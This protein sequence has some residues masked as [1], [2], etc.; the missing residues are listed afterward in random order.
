MM[1][2]PIA[3]T[4]VFL[5][6]RPLKVNLTNATHVLVRLKL[7]QRIVLD[8]IQVSDNCV[9]LSSIKQLTPSIVTQLLTFVSF[10]R[11]FYLLHLLPG[12]WKNTSGDC[13]NCP[14]GFFSAKQNVR[15]CTTC[16]IGWFASTL[17]NQRDRCMS[18]PR[19][20]FGVAIAATSLMEGCSNCSS[21]RFSEMEAVES[22][23][24]CKG[25]AAGKWSAVMGANSEI[26]CQNCIA[27]RY[28]RAE[29]N[30]A[31]SETSCINCPIGKYLERVGGVD[32]SLC[33]SCPI[34]YSQPSAGN[35][36]CLP[37]TPGAFQTVVGQSECL[38]CSIA[39]ASTSV[40]RS[41]DCDVCAA[42]RNQPNTGMT[43][44]LTCIP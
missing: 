37:C 35:A 43:T 32:S 17:N 33:K 30:G 42:G 21:G 18:C 44:C 20:T 7:A 24:G 41:T 28:G 13:N 38:P 34:G 8:V 39:R 2:P 40:A 16:P 29:S 15:V 12:T 25:C 4:V 26:S 36:F 23:S 6:F 31:D 19:G 22:P 1:M 5:R 14:L 9:V 11:I 27:G 10:S 3:K